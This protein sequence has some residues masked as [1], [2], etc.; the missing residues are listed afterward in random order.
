MLVGYSGRQLGKRQGRDARSRINVTVDGMGTWAVMDG[1]EYQG[2]V[3]HEKTEIG[4]AV[5]AGGGDIVTAMNWQ[6]SESR[7]REVGV[8]KAPL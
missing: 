1:K 8:L 5:A 2:A 4:E 6:A 3:N 7:R